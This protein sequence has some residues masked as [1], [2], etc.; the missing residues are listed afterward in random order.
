MSDKYRKIVVLE[1][2][3]QAQLL[4]ALL[5]E[6]GIPHLMRSYH[7]SALDGLFQGPKGWGHV[8]APEACRQQIL[9]SLAELSRGPAETAESS[10]S[11]LRD[12]SDSR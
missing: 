7:D 1:T 4:D 2:E 6:Q 3:V 9:E 5:T 8:E 10:E 11:E 12:D